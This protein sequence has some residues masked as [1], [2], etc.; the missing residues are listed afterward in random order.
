MFFLSKKLAFLPSH[1][2]SESLGDMLG[3]DPSKFSKVVKEQTNVEPELPEHLKNLLT[4]EEKYEIL[5]KDLKD[6]Q[7]Y[8]SEKVQTK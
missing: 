1:L 6:I 5:P 3:A 2:I 7:N 4:K 8:I